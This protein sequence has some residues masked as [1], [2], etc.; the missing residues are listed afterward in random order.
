MEI[1]ET[2]PSILGKL[3]DHDHDHENETP[4]TSKTPGA[5]GIEKDKAEE[6]KLLEAGE[7]DCI[8]HLTISIF[9][10]MEKEVNQLVKQVSGKY[11]GSLAL[12][13]KLQTTNDQYEYKCEK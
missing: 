3:I 13:E 6:K 2:D 7:Q 12:I 11:H 5:A 10:R 9:E 4:D 1:I 8:E